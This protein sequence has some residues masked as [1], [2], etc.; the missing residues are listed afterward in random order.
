MSRRWE[1]MIPADDLA[2]H[3]AAGYG[4]TLGLGR[5]P[6][7]LVIDL[8]YRFLG[9]HPA[10]ILEAV[11]RWPKSVG[12]QGWAALPQVARLLEASRQAAVPVIYTTGTADGVRGPQFHKS[13]Q[14]GDEAAVEVDERAI[15]REVAPAGELVIAKPGPSPFFGTPLLA[16]LVQRQIDTLLLAGCTTSGCVRATA[17]DAA[18]RGFRVAVVEE[19]VFDRFRISH[20]V[21]L[22]DLH[23]KYADVM[24]LADVI[25]Y[26]ASIGRGGS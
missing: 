1:A 13:R 16:Y 22:F 24:A 19:C 25:E 12:A 14:Q 20:E 23:A 26:L 2:V 17:V 5:R 8:N 9:R 10:P 3:H 11:R 15:V 21:A 4:R 6:A 18:T 7:T